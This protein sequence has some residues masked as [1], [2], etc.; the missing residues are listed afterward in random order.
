ML[1][2]LNFLDVVE[3]PNDPFVFCRVCT[4][5]VAA[6]PHST[7]VDY[8][9]SPS[10]SLLYRHLKQYHGAAKPSIL[11]AL[12]CKRPRLAEAL[13]NSQYQMPSLSL[14]SARHSRD[15]KSGIDS[16]ARSVRG[17]IRSVA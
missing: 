1:T 2:S 16:N 6:N 15:S 3:A 10:K 12:I 14:I 13:A 9:L 7:G 17:R 4:S 5:I 11:P 8:P